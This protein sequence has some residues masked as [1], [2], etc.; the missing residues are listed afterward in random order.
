M[1]LAASSFDT[2]P[3]F[4][5]LVVGDGANTTSVA[6][7]LAWP[8][9]DAD[10]L[11]D[12]RVTVLKQSW[13]ADSLKKGAL[14]DESTYKLAAARDGSGS[15]AAGVGGKRGRDEGVAGLPSTAPGN[16]SA[17]IDLTGDTSPTTS[18]AAQPPAAKRHQTQSSLAG[19]FGG[20]PKPGGNAAAPASAAP[21]H[22]QQSVGFAAVT[23]ASSVQEACVIAGYPF[24][25]G[26]CG[27]DTGVVRLRASAIEGVDITAGRDRINTWL[28]TTKGASR[29]GGS[30][31]KPTLH[32]GTH[33]DAFDT[34]F[35]LGGSR[36]SSG[37][38][39]GAHA[40]GAASSSSS[41]GAGA[42]DVI[43]LDGAGGDGGDAVVAA[44]PGRGCPRAA[45]YTTM[46]PSRMGTCY[47]YSFVPPSSAFAGSGHVL[48]TAASSSSS[49]A[50]PSPSTTAG[51]CIPPSPRILS[52]DLDGTLI[53]PTNP[54]A[55][56]CET[57]SDWKWVHPSV[58]SII[59]EWH[60]TK[61]YKVVLFSNQKGVSTGKQDAATVCARALAVA[62]AIDVP[63]QIFLA[64]AQDFFRKPCVG[65]WWLMAAKCNGG[66]AVDMAQS[67]YVGD[68]AGRP[69][70]GPGGC[71]PRDHSAGDLAFA[72]NLGLPFTTPEHFFAGS[73]QFL[74][75]NPAA[76]I[77]LDAWSPGAAAAAVPA[78]KGKAPSASTGP[79]VAAISNSGWLPALHL[80]RP[81]TDLVVSVTR[82][83]GVSSLSGGSAH[84]G[85][86]GP[87][88]KQ[89]A[90]GRGNVEIVLL[91]APPGCGK[92][93]LCTHYF[94]QQR[95][96]VR[97]NQDQLK[98]REKCV[99]L[100]TA[101]I[102]GANGNG[103]PMSAVVDATNIDAATRREWV[104]LARSLG[105]PIRAVEFSGSPAP[106]AAPM[107]PAKDVAMHLN[108]LREVSPLG[109]ADGIHDK[110]AVPSMVVHAMYKRWQPV[111][112][113]G[114]GIDEVARVRFV[115]GPYCDVHC[116]GAAEGT[117]A[118]SGAANA[119]GAASA[120]SS[121]APA[122]PTSRCDA[123]AFA[124]ALV[125]SIVDV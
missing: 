15:S 106:S 112:V 107:P 4:S 98:T 11:R 115:P 79:V 22:P 20:A 125:Y 50:S 63:M 61:G 33:I 2:T 27:D 44:A 41:A 7:A 57:A 43:V 31:A 40:A 87:I 68:A 119:A 13:L 114:E 60:A 95:G 120:P 121:S 97:V 77:K 83:D 108:S 104:A 81:C 105:V 103:E 65:M 30:A 73:N 32:Y 39:Q 88:A 111:D 118:A 36:N 55:K 23:A 42:D 48:G 28:C 59:R 89:R 12:S 84:P 66:V 80:P 76:T 45:A 58:P 51:D 62:K 75:R 78:S 71:M 72:I 37:S 99:Q 16:D 64:P 24:L 47:V 67:V 34:P 117:G 52:L 35:R 110:R 124:R 1:V 5:K 100:V 17:L 94:T 56:F 91:I 102:N 109:G 90:R 96:Y 113:G 92:S 70:R 54:A 86:N 85:V 10:K 49:A 21:T 101:S 122:S 9:S 6:S 19:F 123:C 8:T 46:S 53:Q 38:G 93:S 82:R 29:A 3:H 18:A 116:G 25:R 69:K 26:L 14:L 74:D